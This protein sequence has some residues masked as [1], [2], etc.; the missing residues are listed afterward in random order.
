MGD[1]VLMQLIQSIP[2]F[3]TFFLFLLNLAIKRKFF[4]ISSLSLLYVSAAMLGSILLVEKPRT[5]VPYVRLDAMIFLSICFILLCLPALFFKDGKKDNDLKFVDLPDNVVRFTTYTLCILTVPASLFYLYRSIPPLLFYL[6]SNL[7]RGAFRDSLEFGNNFSSIESFITRCGA[8]FGYCAFFMAIYCFALKKQKFWVILLLFFGALAT[9]IDSLK[10]VTRFVIFHNMIFCAVCVILFLA[11]IPE[12]RKH[13]IKRFFLLFFVIMSIPFMA[14]SIA[15]FKDN[16]IYSMVSYFATGPYSF[17]V[18]YA[19]RTEGGV[20]AGNGY[21]ICGLH[22]YIYDKILDTDTYTEKQLY[23]ENFYW[24]GDQRLGN[25]PE[26]DNIYRGISGAYSGEFKTIAGMF[27]LDFSPGGVLLLMFL[28]SILFSVA[29]MK[30]KIRSPAGTLLAAFYFYILI[31]SVM[32]WTFVG[33]FGFMVVC[34]I[35]LFCL[36]L[37]IQR[38]KALRSLH[39]PDEQQNL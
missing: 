18:D 7:G 36:H 28:I 3:C 6:S 33:K 9:A 26:I 38:K 29:F 12:E 4:C 8:T 30:G 35:L 34:L 15:R 2:F 14:I 17:N 10:T 27:L 13:T 23:F 21:L 31:L 5:G 20:K 22:Y 24:G 1:T 19:A 32:G 16:I 25:S 11:I 39:S 37:H